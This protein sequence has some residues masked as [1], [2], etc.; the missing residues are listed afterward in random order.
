M[1]SRKW[2]LAMLLLKEWSELGEEGNA[3]KVAFS[4]S[5]CFKERSK[6][7]KK[8]VWREETHPGLS[9]FN[10]QISTLNILKIVKYS[11]PSLFFLFLLR[12]L[13]NG[14]TLNCSVKKNPAFDRKL[15][16]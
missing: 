10:L 4:C 5:C 2:N 6:K 13:K 11:T 1:C 15:D 7:K 12:C 8:S 14:L 9:A 16:L 3:T